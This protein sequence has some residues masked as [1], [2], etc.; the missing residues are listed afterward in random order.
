MKRKRMKIFPGK[1]EKLL[2]AT[3]IAFCIGISIGLVASLNLSDRVNAIA[4]LLAAG[5]GAYIAFYLS[6][7]RRKKDIIERNI[8]ASNLALFNLISMHNSF[9]KYRNQFID[10]ERNSPIRYIS[11]LPSIGFEKWGHQFEYNSLGFLL[12]SDNPNILYELY[13]VQIETTTTVDHIL[14]RNR[15]HYEIVQQN[16]SAAGLKQSDRV[17]EEQLSEAIGDYYVNVLKNMTE[18]MI[19][20]V[21]SLI[22]LYKQKADSL[23]R[24]TKLMY[25]NSTITFMRPLNKSLNCDAKSGAR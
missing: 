19:S 10:P 22:S 18:D 23:H 3:I 25:P 4:T 17:T 14:E 2:T 15:I 20:N 16:L 11:I 24:T 21:D 7:L 8:A 12:G 6:D 13:E 5:V 1:N 9:V